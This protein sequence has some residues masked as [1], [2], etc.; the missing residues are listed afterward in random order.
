M[1]QKYGSWQIEGNNAFRQWDE[2]AI[3]TV[4]LQSSPHGVIA[5]GWWPRI[6]ETPDVVIAGVCVWDSSWQ[7]EFLPRAGKHDSPA[8]RKRSPALPAERREMYERFSQGVG[9]SKIYVPKTI[10]KYH[11]AI[12]GWQAKK[13]QE[14]HP[15][16]V[17]YHVPGKEYHEF[18]CA[19]ERRMGSL[20]VLHDMLDQFVVELTEY[21]KA[22]LSGN[23]EFIQPMELGA[24]SSEESFLLPYLSP[25]LF[26]VRREGMVGVEDLTELNLTVIAAQRIHLEPIN[27]VCTVLDIPH[28]YFGK[29]IHDGVAVIT[30]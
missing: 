11:Q 21:I 19:I 30:L 22:R 29:N 8:K 1:V 25:E 14:L 13:I 27:V 17:L 3:I 16:R 26:G 24:Q 28:P 7:F 20:P 15:K 12:I 9:V 10:G 6:N 4:N 18:I 2:S 5:E 23:V